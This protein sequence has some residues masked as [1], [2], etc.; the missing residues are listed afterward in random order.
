MTFPACCNAHM[1]LS[2]SNIGVPNHDV[3]D[4]RYS[5]AKEDE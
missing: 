3:P 4:L 2:E 5:L 1:H